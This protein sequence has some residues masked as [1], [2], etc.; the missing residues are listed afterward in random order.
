MSE[1]PQQLWLDKIL[2]GRR[3]CL[4]SNDMMTLLQSSAAS[5]V[6]AV[7]PQYFSLQ[8]SLVCVESENCP[9][10]RKLWL[11]KHEDVRRSKRVRAI[12]DELIALF[13]PE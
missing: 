4:R 12:A 1:V 10:M 11:V 2:G 9:V 7:L 5:T 6:V 3:Y 8:C 13:D